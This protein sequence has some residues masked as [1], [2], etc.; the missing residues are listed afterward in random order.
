MGIKQ[1]FRSLAGRAEKEDNSQD[2]WKE[3]DP[4]RNDITPY[5]DDTLGEN[6]EPSLLATTD[7]EPGDV[8]PE[9][10][11]GPDSSDPRITT[12]IPDGDD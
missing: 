7:T 11:K 3:I 12:V 6:T 5:S 2:E 4:A 1:L 10:K 9:S 8:K